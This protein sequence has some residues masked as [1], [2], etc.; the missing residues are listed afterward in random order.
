MPGYFDEDGN[1]V[2]DLISKE[3]SEQQMEELRQKAE[4]AEEE[5]KELEELR[6][7][8]LNFSKLRKSLSEKKEE[9]KEELKVE[10][11]KEEPKVEEPKTIEE[12]DNLLGEDAE[13]EE[14]AKAYY[15]YNQLAKGITDPVL[16]RAFAKVAIQ[17]AQL[18]PLAGDSTD[19]NK[20]LSTN[21]SSGKVN[22]ATEKDTERKQM[23]KTV[24]RLSD[25]DMEAYGKKNWT[26]RY[27]H[28]K[29]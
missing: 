25:E 3:E 8:D 6:K 18:N 1:E 19:F 5:R 9:Q 4:I 14:K 26:P 2:P 17:N 10:I 13:E 20:A 23:G 12:I 11:K 21:F 27:T 7:K 16:K 28:L 22:K 29:K 24:F 15:Y